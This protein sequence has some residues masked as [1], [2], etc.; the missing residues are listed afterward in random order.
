MPKSL[1]NQHNN[2]HNNTT[3]NNIRSRKLIYNSSH[4]IF[5]DVKSSNKTIPTNTNQTDIYP[6]ID[7]S[8]NNKFVSGIEMY[9]D[10]KY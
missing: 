6:K 8:K 1:T 7:L 10:K 3:Q 4:S 5:N 9:V 2:I